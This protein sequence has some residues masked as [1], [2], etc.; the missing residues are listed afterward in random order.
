MSYCVLFDFSTGLSAP[1][2][3]PL[4]TKEQ[5]LERVNSVE[6]T[7]GIKRTQYEDNPPHW[8]HWD[9]E[10]RQGFPSVDD[11]TLCDTAEEHNG[12]VRWL[13]GRLAEWSEN[14][15]AG[16]ELLTP[17]DATEFWPGLRMVSVSPE[18]WTDSYYQERM[19]GI[20]ETMRGRGS[21]GM[22]IDDITPLSPE[23][24]NAV[25]CL[26][27]QYLDTGDIRLEVM[28]DCDHLSNS[29]E[30]RWCEKCGAVDPYRFCDNEGCPLN[31]DEDS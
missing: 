28:K 24:A 18:R 21:E 16:G 7:L 23:Q 30:Y 29:N 25:I 1:L 27:S 12:W 22:S 2:T 10:Y 4:G 14:P 11:K 5:C 15:V 17:E 19:Q 8:D 26:F 13:Y 3:V 20:Y 9:D 31:E 6:R